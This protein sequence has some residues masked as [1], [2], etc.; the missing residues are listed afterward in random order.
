MFELRELV[1]EV[2]ETSYGARLHL[3]LFFS[4]IAQ[5]KADVNC[6][7]LVELLTNVVLFSKVS[8]SRLFANMPLT[9]EAATTNHATGVLLTSAGCTDSLVPDT[10]T[11]MTVLGTF[12]DS[13]TR[14]LLRL[15][16][17]TC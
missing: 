11:D 16:L 13:L 7:P 8:R 9:F 17:V 10:V 15:T 12:A 1:N 2:C 14:H 4:E 6:V 3:N 5:A